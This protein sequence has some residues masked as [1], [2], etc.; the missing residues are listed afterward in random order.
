MKNKKVLFILV[1]IPIIFGFVYGLN[2][3]EGKFDKNK[4]VNQANIDALHKSENNNQNEEFEFPTL[5]EYLGNEYNKLS[6]EE[7]KN[8]EKI[9][10]KLE[11]SMVNMNEE[12]QEE[13]SDL[14][15]Q[16]DYEMM[17]YNLLVPYQDYMQYIDKIENKFTKVEL[18]KLKNLN[19]KIY[20]L[21]DKINTLN[22]SEV[23]KDINK[24]NDEYK[25]LIKKRAEIFE[26]KGF[27]PEEVDNQIQNRSIN[28]A[29]FDVKDGKINLSQDSIRKESEIGRDNIK[30]YQ[31]I[32]GEIVKIVPKEF[33]NK[34]S[35]FEVNTDGI[36]NV[37]AYVKPENMDL[38][39][40]RIAVDLKDAYDEDENYLKEFKETLVH[41]LAHLIT[42]NKDQMKDL[43][44]EMSTTYT[45]E[46]GTLK[47][48]SYLNIFYNKFW[49]DRIK[50]HTKLLSDV[51][52]DEMEKQDKLLDFY[53]KYKD[54]F[55]SD[56]S[57]TNP[58]EDI[59]ESFRCFVIEDKPKND[60][61]RN[62]KVLF[63]Y[64]FNEFVEYRNQIRS[65]LN[66][67]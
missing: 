58:P 2:K 10:T 6:K 66:L 45:V 18:D 9:Y 44:S 56:Y 27:N 61:I 41:E 54:E 31:K 12:N 17:K 46:E 40:W 5:K 19:S 21:E 14:W 22:E 33:I 29:L 51:Q 63:F 25:E 34:I 13:I 8:I 57:A 7:I 60:S 24:T 47:N 38:S 3:T 1:I 23:I 59:A 16:L 30:K 43:K 64:D 36:D 65:A 42:L 67:K 62:K 26:E 53:E 49:T 52:Y 20:E 28:I 50:E 37:L 48:N 4:N 35:K 11:S 32:W 15:V 55:V 39:K